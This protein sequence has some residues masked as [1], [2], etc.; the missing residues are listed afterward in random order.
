M[1]KSM[2]I[3]LSA[4][5]EK[6]NLCHNACTNFGHISS[7]YLIYRLMRNCIRSQSNCKN[8]KCFIYL[9]PLSKTYHYTSFYLG[10]L[11]RTYGPQALNVDYFMMANCLISPILFIHFCLQI[12]SYDSNIITSVKKVVYRKNYE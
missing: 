3:S 2:T 5:F 10:Y 8:L 9:P 12:V 1:K 11:R 7:R 6:Q 4:F